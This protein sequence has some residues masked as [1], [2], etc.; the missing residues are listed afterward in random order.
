LE[1]KLPLTFKFSSELLNSQ[2][3]QGNLAR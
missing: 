2:K 3:I 1:E